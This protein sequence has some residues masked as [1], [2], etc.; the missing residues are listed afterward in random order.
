MKKIIFALMSF[1]GIFSMN[2]WAV[3]GELTIYGY[4]T[5]YTT[6][7]YSNNVYAE[8][9][10][11]AGAMATRYGTN[12]S[13]IAWAA[14]QSAERRAQKCGAEKG[15]IEKAHADCKLGV[16][17][18]NVR[19]VERCGAVENSEWSFA[20]MFEPKH[21]ILF[22]SVT[23]TIQDPTYDKCMDKV[24]TLNQIEG[25]KCNKVKVD[26]EDIARTANNGV[27]EDFYK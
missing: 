9:R 25:V 3:D 13:A 16:A 4:Q 17:T 5:T 7:D 27:C 26:S 18:D 6:S 22:A 19:E 21:S 14:Q 10:S 8:W 11:S 15:A 12:W 1:C 20:A 23:Y 24:D 2:A